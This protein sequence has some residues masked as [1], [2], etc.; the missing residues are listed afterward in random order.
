M[1]EPEVAFADLNDVMNLAEDLIVSVVGRVLEKRKP[2]LKVLERDISKLETVQKPFP[3]ITY[4]EAIEI[5]QKNGQPEA[6][7][8]TTSAATRRPSSR[9][10]SIGP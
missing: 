4:D 2:E 10:S 1:V 5:L 6:N 7:G 8:A 9:T 3:R